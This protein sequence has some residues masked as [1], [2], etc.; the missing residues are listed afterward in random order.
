MRGVHDEMSQVD[1]AIAGHSVAF[2]A[3]CPLFAAIAYILDT[4]REKAALSPFFY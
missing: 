2:Q 4:D 1:A 3:S